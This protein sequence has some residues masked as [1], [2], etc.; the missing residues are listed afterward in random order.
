MLQR[1]SCLLARLQR[2]GLKNHVFHV[3]A[4]VHQTA[5]AIVQKAMTAVLMGKQTSLDHVK[6]TIDS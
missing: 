2:R 4:H 6:E 5:P 1:K 3:F